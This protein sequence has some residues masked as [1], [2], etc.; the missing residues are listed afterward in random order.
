MGKLAN[1]SLNDGT[2]ASQGYTEATGETQTTSTPVGDVVITFYTKPSLEVASDC[3]VYQT[4]DGKCGESTLNCLYVAPAKLANP[5]L[6]DGT[7]ADQGYTV[8]TGE[9][10]TTSTPVGDIVI[11]FYTQSLKVPS[12][13]TVYSIGDGKCGE[14]TL[15]CLNVAPAKLA[16]PS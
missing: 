12:D 3:T 16:N 2:C 9:T 5:S 6:K 4:G 10:Q 7:C 15:N 1:P 14:S 13:C 11:T 8:A